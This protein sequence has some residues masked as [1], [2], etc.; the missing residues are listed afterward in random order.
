MMD[1]LASHADVPRGARLWTFG[2]PR[3]SDT[4]GWTA[5]HGTIDA[6]HGALVLHPADGRI[7]LRSPAD[8]LIR[9]RTLSR[10]LLAIDGAPTLRSVAIRA[11]AAGESSWTIVARSGTSRLNL[12]WP[13]A[14]RRGSTIIEGIEI[15]ITFADPASTHRL[16]RVLLYPRA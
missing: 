2:S 4:D 6:D 7:V 12:D 8:Q 13:P 5:T 14:W 3:L 11:R 9:P 16:A 1:F 10:V 15:D